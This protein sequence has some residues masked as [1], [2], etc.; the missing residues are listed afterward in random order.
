LTNTAGTI[1]VQFKPSSWGY[2]KVGDMTIVEMEEGMREMVLATM[3][4][5][6]W[7]VG[8]S[9]AKEARKAE[10]YRRSCKE[11]H[12]KACDVQHRNSVQVQTRGNDAWLNGMR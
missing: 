5:M 8:I 11:E 4:A 1:I 6:D 10:E 12:R 9:A 7:S 3:V 2:T